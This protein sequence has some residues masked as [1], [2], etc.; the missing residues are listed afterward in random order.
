MTT[1]QIT[2][3]HCASCV[4]KIEKALKAVPGVTKASVNFATE[5][6]SIDGEVP[7]ETL[8]AA[9]ARVGGYKIVP[10]E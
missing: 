8:A 10:M 4:V 7:I 1:Y 3:I 9:V 6:A 2:G 5:T